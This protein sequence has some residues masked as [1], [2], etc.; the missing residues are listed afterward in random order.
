[1]KLNQ[2]A[3]FCRLSTRAALVG[4]VLGLACSVS[5]AQSPSPQHPKRGWAGTVLSPYTSN[6]INAN[7]YYT[8]GPRAHAGS[9]AEFIPM[10][11]NGGA[12]TNP[13]NFAALT[14]HSSEWILGFNEPERAEQA[15]MTPDQALALWPQLMATG[16]KLVSP[17]VG[18]D[19]HGRAW[20][21]EFMAKAN[22]LNA[23][24][25]GT[26]RIDAIGMHW[27]GDVRVTNAWGGLS[28]Q[29]D[30][31][32][33]T[34]TLNGTKLPIWL[35]EFAGLDFTNGANPV[36]EE[37]NRRFL[38]GALPM[39]DSK[40]SLARYA[41][42]NW[43][44][45]AYLGTLPAGATDVP[46][47]PYTTTDPG[48][49][50][51][52]RTYSGASTYTI[53]GN[54]GTD[55]FYFRGATI[56]NTAATARTI[57]AIDFIEGSSSIQGTADVNIGDWMWIRSG[58]TVGKRGTNALNFAGSTLFNEGTLSGKTGMMVFSDGAVVEGAG[59]IRTEWNADA[60]PEG[61]TFTVS[62][63][64]EAGVTCNNRIWLNGGQFNILAGSHT[65]NGN[66][67]MASNSWVNVTGN[68][69]VNGQIVPHAPTTVAFFN[70]SGSGTLRLNAGSTNLGAMNITAG[71][72]VV[73]N[74]TGSAHGAG[75]LTI[76]ALAT[77]SGN[78][79]LGGT[80]VVVNGT[81]SPDKV[82]SRPRPLTLNSPLTFGAAAR[83][84]M[85]VGLIQPD[86]VDSTSTVTP[87]GVLQLVANIL[88]ADLVPMTL[89]TA[90]SVVGI[91]DTVEGVQQPSNR[92]LAVTYTATTIVATKTL[93]GDAN[94]DGK[95]D[96]GDLLNLASNY[97][98]TS[99]SWATGDFSGDGATNFTD[100]LLLAQ[101]YGTNLTGQFGSSAAMQANFSADWARAVEMAAVPEPATV[102]LVPGL[103]LLTRRRR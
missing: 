52:G 58:I 67:Q 9:Y 88:P 10:A 34:F 35:T 3:R 64:T 4:A 22:A 11:W 1:L 90:S 27:Y 42:F 50:Y 29:I 103:W 66:V 92:A 31:F 89:F 99:R 83:T 24:N 41:W 96:F 73:G 85:D 100:L 65:L 14:S 19:S 43:R 32:H 28:S 55:T 36:T 26:I 37:D 69:T 101:N 61:I 48:D 53:V 30:D 18:S 98:T 23:A 20:M 12:I 7:W 44:P 75:L 2:P 59:A 60:T 51:N 8:W 6:R 33:N 72:L 81:L 80:G 21:T 95:V 86:S 56:Q 62:S 46:A 38:A 54:E 71:T 87:N 17:N 39:L 93:P 77:L 57:R 47:S 40:A 16:K 68:L 70:K 49:L 15:N 79:T 82:T 25:P 78:G 97:E 84:V 102:M 76:A 94:V 63:A 91:F 45:E 5:S 74:E 13:T